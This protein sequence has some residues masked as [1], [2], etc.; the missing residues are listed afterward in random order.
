MISNKDKF[1]F[2]VPLE[3]EKGKGDKPDYQ[4]MKVKGIAST[5]DEDADEE[6][7]EPSGFE[8]AKF[9][10]SGFI[11]YNHQSTTKPSAL[12]GEPTSAKIINGK[13]NIQG[14]LYPDSPTAREVY[15]TAIMLEKNSETRRLGYSIEG[16]VI[17]RDLSNPKRILKAII[18][19]CAITPK[20]KN[21]HTLLEVVKGEVD[22]EESVYEVET[23][24][25]ADANGGNIEYL[26][27]IKD[28][29]G[30]RMT[31]DKNL[32]INI[33]K[34]YKKSLDNK[35]YNSED[36]NEDKKAMDIAAVSPLLPESVEGKDRKKIK[37]SDFLNKSQIYTKIF[38]IFTDD[39]EKA[40]KVYHLLKTIE[41]VTYPNMDPDKIQIS[42]E[43]IAKAEEILGIVSK[44][45]ES[46]NENSQKIEE[47]LKGIDGLSP[48]KITEIVKAYSESM[49][50][51]AKEASQGGSDDSRAKKENQD[52]D[53]ENALEGED[54]FKANVNKKNKAETDDLSK[55][56]GEQ[57]TEKEAIT[58]PVDA[59]AIVKS[60]TDNI[61]TTLDTKFQ[62]LGQLYVASKQEQ[63]EMQ[64]SIN[65]LK[66]TN[67]TLVGRLSDVE[68]QPAS[69]GKS[70]MTKG[71]KERFENTNGGVTLSVS[72]NKNQVIELLS[73]KSGFNKSEDGANIDKEYSIAI[74][75]M[76]IASTITNANTIK[77]LKEEEGVT[78]V[79]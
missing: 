29:T 3:I 44:G 79:S 46:S 56:E 70:I 23:V 39:I 49:P 71:F 17:E 52:Q 47:I 67:E 7:L 38:S 50:P 36:E 42:D 32:N 12:I 74:Q 48:E 19:G 5:R 10:K 14:M 69:N 45:E 65:D 24:E 1:N 58:D 13:L 34:N 33:D 57:S 21:S 51:P 43:T 40:K 72:K 64:K 25:K 53:D 8:L 30:A 66:E 27:D 28:E 55:G 54:G 75:E 6:I 77:R 31:I 73:E 60:I 41:Q 26:V 16:K 22:F 11:N 9:V 78:L 63:G 4:N 59:D 37:K 18:T 15:D 61:N 2:F 62:A 76:E 68:K 20:P 35:T